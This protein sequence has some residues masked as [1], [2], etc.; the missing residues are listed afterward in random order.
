MSHTACCTPVLHCNLLRY[1][2]CCYYYLYYDHRCS[3]KHPVGGWPAVNALSAAPSPRTASTEG[4]RTKALTVPLLPMTWGLL[5]TKELPQFRCPQSSTS[6]GKAMEEGALDD[7]V[8]A[9]STA[10]LHRMASSSTAV[11]A[12]TPS[13]R[14]MLP[15]RAEVLPS[16][17]V[18]LNGQWLLL[19]GRHH[20]PSVPSWGTGTPCTCGAPCSTFRFVSE[21]INHTARLPLLQPHHRLA[22]SAMSI[23][24]QLVPN[25]VVLES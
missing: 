15:Q 1:Y 12:H 5:G 9:A 19:G 24:I 4:C 3:V 13:N 2:H 25:T 20:I 6:P 21:D 10:E 22:L 18:A 17:G 16:Y 8:E 7:F 23:H 11:S 14:A